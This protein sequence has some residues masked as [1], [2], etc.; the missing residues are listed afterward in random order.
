MSYFTKQNVHWGLSLR[1]DGPMKNRPERQRNFF[2]KNRLGDKTVFSA[3]LEHGNKVQLIGP[4]DSADNMLT[5]DALISDRRDCVL[6]VTVADCLPIYFYDYRRRVVAIVHAGWRSVS[7]Q[8]VLKVVESLIKNYH[9][10]P[11]DIE[12]MIGPHI[13]SCHFA[14]QDD[15]AKH[16]RDD[17]IIFKEG[18]MFVDLA[19]AVCRQLNA[20]GVGA[21]IIIVS[22][23]CTYCHP[24]RYF[25]FRRDRPAEL[26]AMVAYVGLA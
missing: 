2:A 20:V 24:D 10:A 15:V 17:E 12:V 8:I 22:P 25:S 14:V 9:S 4:T 1:Q 5:G 21:N 19:L 16:F 26:E 13:K 7:S 11:K 6:T 3:S 18:R 23:D